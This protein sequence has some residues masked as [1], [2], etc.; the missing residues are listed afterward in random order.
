VSPQRFANSVS[1]LPDH[2]DM[3]AAAKH[4]PVSASPVACA[5]GYKASA[6]LFVDEEFASSR[7]QRE[8]R[9]GALLFKPVVRFCSSHYK[10]VTDSGGGKRIV[11]VGVGHEDRLDGLG[12]RP[13]P[14]SQVAPGAASRRKA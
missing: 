1:E 3:V 5:D 6:M 11:Q 8:T 7:T 14:P 12:F 9:L 4:M 13:P 10:Y 2:A